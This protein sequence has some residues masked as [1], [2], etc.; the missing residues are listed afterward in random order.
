MHWT[1]SVEKDASGHVT[2]KLRDS[3]IET[4]TG[5]VLKE[6]ARVGLLP[7]WASCR[8]PS[9]ISALPFV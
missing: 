3:I 7:L 6:E 5:K 1:P 2:L 8:V 9:F 4:D